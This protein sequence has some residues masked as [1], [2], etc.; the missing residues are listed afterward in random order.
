[1]NYS[2][3]VKREEKTEKFHKMHRLRKV[4]FGIRTTLRQN[5]PASLLYRKNRTSDFFFENWID[6]NQNNKYPNK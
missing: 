3:K 1:M 5:S 4:D 6:N 2:K